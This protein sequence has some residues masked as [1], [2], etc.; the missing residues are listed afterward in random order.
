MAS[1]VDVLL[2][3]DL[4]SPAEE[5][6][7]E[8]FF[9]EWRWSKTRNGNPKFTVGRTKFILF[10]HSGL[11]RWVA[12][13]WPTNEREWARVSR[14]TVE[15]AKRDAWAAASA[16]WPIRWGDAGSNDSGLSHR[17]YLHSPRKRAA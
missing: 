8:A 12:I 2:D 3:Q 10:R 11:W 1:F 15:D 9:T 5:A 6:A 17:F 4:P 7:R 14:A 13:H 16:R